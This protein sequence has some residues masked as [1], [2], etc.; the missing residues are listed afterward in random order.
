[1]YVQQL[2]PMKNKQTRKQKAYFITES[3]TPYEKRSF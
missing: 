3:K 2:Y 1:M